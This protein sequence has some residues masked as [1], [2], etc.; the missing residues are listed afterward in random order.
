MPVDLDETTLVVEINDLEG[1]ERA[2]ATGDVPCAC[3]SPR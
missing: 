1:L 3:S 2:L